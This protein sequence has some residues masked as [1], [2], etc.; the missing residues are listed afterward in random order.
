MMFKACPSS[1]NA[2][3]I[4]IQQASKISWAPGHFYKIPGTSFHT[5]YLW[6]IVMV[7]TPNAIGFPLPVPLFSVVFPL[8]LSGDGVYFF[9][10]NPGWPVISFDQKN[11]GELSLQRH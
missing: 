5:Y 9:P 3:A 8:L 10:I 11:V 4:F 2:M 7:M 6:S 1:K